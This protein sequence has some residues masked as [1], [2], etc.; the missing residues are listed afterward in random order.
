M[1]PENLAALHSDP[2]PQH[3]LNGRSY[4][5]LIIGQSH[6]PTPS[7][8]LFRCISHDKWLSGEGKHFY[9]VIVITNGHDLFA[10]DAA[11]FGPSFEGMALGTPL[12]QHVHNR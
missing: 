9:V 8:Q 3:L 12:V 11:I 7:P 6:W 1:S 2:R 5:V 4:S 10:G